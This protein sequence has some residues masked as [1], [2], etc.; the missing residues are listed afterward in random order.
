MARRRLSSK[1][2]K[3]LSFGLRERLIEIPQ[4]IV[5]IFDADRQTDHVR[6]NT[7]LDQVFFGQLAVSRR[8]G[9]NDQCLGIAD[10]SQMRKKLQAFD[11]LHPSLQPPFDAEGH[12]G[13]AAL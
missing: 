12:D 6:A 4:D 2:V 3:G 1:T 5:D 7:G 13:A 8:S 9:M 11:E 10:V